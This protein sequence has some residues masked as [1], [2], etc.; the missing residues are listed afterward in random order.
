M[1]TVYE[2]EIANAVRAQ[3]DALNRRLTD[4]YRAGLQVELHRDYGRGDGVGWRV[5]V[6]R[7]KD[8][9]LAE[10]PGRSK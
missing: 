1:A 4:A 8:E 3:V 5:K 10:T 9:V 6:Y 7:S 2:M